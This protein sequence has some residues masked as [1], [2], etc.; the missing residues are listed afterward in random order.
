MTTAAPR[1]SIVVLTCNRRDEVLRT[2]HGLRRHYPHHPIIVVDNASE[3]GSA[4]A[5]GQAFPDVQLVRAPTNEGAAG[6][7]RGCL[8]ATTPYVAF[9]DDDTCWEAEA[10]ARAE[11][12]LDGWPELALASGQ[13]RVGQQGRPDPTCA[14][15]ARSPLPGLPGI[16]PGLVGFMAGACVVRRAAFL[17][18]GGYWPPLFIGG[19]EGLLAL[20]LLQAGWR[21][22]YA[23]QLVTWHWPSAR[24]DAPR[25]RSLLARNALWLAWMRLP[26]RIAWRQTRRAAVSGNGLRVLAQALP[27][28][29]RA[30]SR[31]RVVSASVLAQL[32]Q[33]EA[34]ARDDRT[35]C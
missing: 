33:V 6:R 22:V 14:V 35:A 31:R 23:P 21:I 10:L 8:A 11:A 27:G 24:R 30:L 17:Q 5:I 7:N 29:P 32:R 3:D 13:V 9:C 16:G 26:A 20:D 12:M 28:L 4:G 34:A 18:A 1:V 2:L 15:M 25:R 19:E